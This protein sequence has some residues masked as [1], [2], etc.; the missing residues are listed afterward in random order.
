[1]FEIFITGF[2]YL[3]TLEGMAHYEG[4]L[5]AP[6]LW[7]SVKVFSPLRQKQPYYAVLASFIPL[8]VFSINQIVT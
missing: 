1:M 3:I 8:L 5:L 7:P 6:G 2:A 4:Q